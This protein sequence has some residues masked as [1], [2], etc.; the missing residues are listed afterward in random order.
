[1]SG[2]GSEDLSASQRDRFQRI[3]MRDRIVLIVSNN[4]YEVSVMKG[5]LRDMQCGAVIVERTAAEALAN[6]RTDRFDVMILRDRLPDGDAFK[7][8]QLLK[9]KGKAF[10]T[11]RTRIVYVLD[12]RRAAMEVLAQAEPDAVIAWPFSLNQFRERIE[13]PF[14]KALRDGAPADSRQAIGAG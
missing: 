13:T 4:D 11:P 6:M 12:R 2:P 5:F 1:M 7:L 8:L 14:G 9:I 10:R 3:T